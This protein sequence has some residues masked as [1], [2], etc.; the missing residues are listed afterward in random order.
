MTTIAMTATVQSPPVAGPWPPEDPDRH[1]EREPEEDP[2]LHD[3]RE[4]D[5]RDPPN[6]PPPEER[7]PPKKLR[8]PPP[9]RNE[10]PPREPPIER[11]AFAMG[12][13]Y[14]V[15][16]RSGILRTSRAPGCGML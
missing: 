4:P 7:E 1:D 6:E 16:L 15:P 2:Q 5:E 3:D 12:A 8:E 13:G 9:P 11:P 14:G 10:P